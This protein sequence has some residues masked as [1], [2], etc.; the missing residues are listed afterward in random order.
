MNKSVIAHS[1]EYLEKKGFMYIR[2]IIRRIRI[3]KIFKSWGHIE[4]YKFFIRSYNSCFPCSIGD[5]EGLM[6]LIDSG[7]VY[8][9][10]VKNG[11]LLDTEFFYHLRINPTIFKLIIF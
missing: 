4:L 7:I 11:E 6:F 1:L 2:K 10:G 9:Y 3:K 8:P 5:D